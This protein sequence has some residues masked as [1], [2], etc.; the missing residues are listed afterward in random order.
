LA[1]STWHLALLFLKFP[2]RDGIPGAP[3]RSFT[4]VETIG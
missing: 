2:A 3:R 1:L 4:R